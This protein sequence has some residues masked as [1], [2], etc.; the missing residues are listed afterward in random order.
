M[1]L[2]R[3]ICWLKIIPRSLGS[4][5]FWQYGYPVSGHEFTQMGGDVEAGTAILKCDIC[6]YISEGKGLAK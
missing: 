5:L 1:K 4:N 3:I 2:L 6:G